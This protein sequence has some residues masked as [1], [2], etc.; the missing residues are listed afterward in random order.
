[1]VLSITGLPYEPPCCTFRE[2][3]LKCV[4]LEQYN[5][6][7]VERNNHL[8][9][10]PL[11]SNYRYWPK[12]LNYVVNAPISN[13]R[14]P[15]CGCNPAVA[16]TPAAFSW[17]FVPKQQ[18]ECRHQNPRRPPTPHVHHTPI[19]MPFCHAT[20]TTLP[21]CARCVQNRLD[22]FRYL[23]VSTSNSWS[24]LLVSPPPWSNQVDASEPLWRFVRVT[25][26][27]STFVLLALAPGQYLP[28]AI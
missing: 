3:T 20:K 16:V 26:K 18:M 15:T 21:L 8:V 5:H 10:Q 13:T 25:T 24:N 22:S 19:M 4:L 12:G 14:V 28:S 27:G 17:H 7:L 11:Y 23:S 2:H 9:G 1:M 6:P